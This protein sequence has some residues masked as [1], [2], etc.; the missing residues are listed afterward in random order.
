MPA[1]VTQVV[2]LDTMYELKDAVQAAIGLID[3]G[4]EVPLNEEAEEVLLKLQK[5]WLK[6][7]VETTK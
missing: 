2:R 1:V 7:Q 4:L 5:A 3:R 6:Y